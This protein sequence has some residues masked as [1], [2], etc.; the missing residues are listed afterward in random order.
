MLFY[1]THFGGA[2]R[3]WQVFQILGKLYRLHVIA[4]TDKSEE[5][6]SIFVQE[7]EKKAHSYHICNLPKKKGVL[8]HF[9]KSG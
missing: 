8:A 9:S 6:R 3:V 5:Q 1:P 7:I 4:F 2:W